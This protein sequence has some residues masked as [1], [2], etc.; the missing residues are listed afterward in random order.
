MASYRHHADRPC[1][2]AR[3]VAYSVPRTLVVITVVAIA[4]ELLIR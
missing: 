4:L 3:P 2:G 1:G